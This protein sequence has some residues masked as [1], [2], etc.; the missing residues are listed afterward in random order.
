M[1]KVVGSFAEA[2]ADIPDGATVMLGGFGL[3]ADLP[4]NLIL[5]LLDCGARELT[6]ITNTPGPGSRLALNMWGVTQWTDAN[7]LVENKQVKRFI[8]TITFPDTA[9]ERAILAG[10]VEVEFV[11]QGTLA[12]RIRAGGFG[13]GGFYVKT[14][15]GTTIVEG[16]E[17]RIINGEEY[18][19]EMPLKADYALIKAYQ[20]DEMGNLIYRGNTRSFNAVMAP[21]AD[22]TIAEV[23]NIVGPGEL[24]PEVIITPEI[25]VDRIVKIPGEER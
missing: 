16:K 8:I 18:F 17:R 11:P 10:E 4:F 20:A 12:E 22:V 19:L 24:E 2:V 21:A 5:A 14:G 6:I 1:S 7:L 25:F 3:A 13:I 15:G 9:A 23:S